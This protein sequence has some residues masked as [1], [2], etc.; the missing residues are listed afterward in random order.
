MRLSAAYNV[1][2]TEVTHLK[3]N[4]PELNA[5]GDSY[6]VFSDREMT[7]FEK[8]TPKNKLNLAAV[9]TRGDWQATFRAS[10]Y[11]EVIDPGSTPAGDEVIKA[12][13]IGDVDVSYQ[14]FEGLKLSVGANN[15]FDEYPQDTVSNIGYSTFNQIFPYSG[16]SSYSIDGRFIYGKLSYTF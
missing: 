1:N 15:L 9:Y 13:W 10:H 11:G 4:P 6:Q 3:A 7:R 8:G 12:A 16:F 2:D 14:L 5:L